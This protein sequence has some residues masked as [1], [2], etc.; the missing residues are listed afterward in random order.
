MPGKESNLSEN[1]RNDLQIEEKQVRSRY[2]M[3]DQGLLEIFDPE[4]RFLAFVS[5]FIWVPAKNAWK[6]VQVVE[7]PQIW[8][9]NSR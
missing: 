3:V 4:S 5:S 7:K 2:G 9:A 6:R 8:S 1:F